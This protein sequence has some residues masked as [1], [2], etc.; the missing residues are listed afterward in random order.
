MKE[1]ALK[2]ETRL[3][4][5]SVNCTEIANSLPK[6]LSSQV[7]KKQLLR[8]CV[9]PALNYGEAQVAESRNDFIHKLRI[10]LKE[11]KETSVNL[12]IIEALNLIKD[13][14]NLQMCILESNE[15]VAIFIS[16]VNTAIKNQE[17]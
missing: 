4:K 7:L 16:S 17:N 14:A 9:S 1:H 10:A 5:F 13:S 11:L 6:D 8:S 15:L 3:I 2:L 12:K